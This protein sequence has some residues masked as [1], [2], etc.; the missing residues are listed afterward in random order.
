MD[1]VK[2]EDSLEEDMVDGEEDEDE[3]DSDDLE[4]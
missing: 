4:V 3:E 1:E 2:N